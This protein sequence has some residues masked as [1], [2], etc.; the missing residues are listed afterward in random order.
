MAKRLTKSDGDGKCVEN[1]EK[2]F[3]LV[4]G[5]VLVNGHGHCGTRQPRMTDAERGCEKVWDDVKRI[6]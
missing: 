6:V 1:A 2:S 3:C 4:D 5:A